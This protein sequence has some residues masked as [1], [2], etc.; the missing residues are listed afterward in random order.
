MSK[1]ELNT[2]LGVK[3]FDALNTDSVIGGN[4]VTVDKEKERGGNKKKKIDIKQQSFQ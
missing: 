3:S 1:L 2:F 4:A